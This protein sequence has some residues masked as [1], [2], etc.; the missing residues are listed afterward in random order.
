MSRKPTPTAAAD[1]SKKGD[2]RAPQRDET[3]SF[4]SEVSEELRRDRLN[5]AFKRY[6]PFAGG[7]IILVVLATAGYEFYRSQSTSAAREAGATLAEAAGS[8]DPQAAFEAAAGA[9]TGGPQM[10]ARFAEASLI[11]QGDTPENAVP[12]YDDIIATPDIDPLYR[13]LAQLRRVMAQLGTA[14]PD[15]LLNEIAP[16]GEPGEPFSAVALEIEA[17]LHLAKDDV[18]AARN[19]LTAALSD[20]FSTPGQRQRLQTLLD[21]LPTPPEAMDA[22]PTTDSESGADQG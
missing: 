3:D 4:I 18:D 21:S 1:A 6:G 14:E 13:K 20:P 9:L 7:A 2:K 16:L 22:A 8:E 15:A 11:S 19:A 5:R 12:I 17:G 10:V